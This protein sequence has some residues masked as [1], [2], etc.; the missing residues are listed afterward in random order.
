MF[1][2]P[3]RHPYYDKGGFFNE[4]SQKATCVYHPHNEGVT[5]ANC[6]R[7]HSFKSLTLKIYI[8]NHFIFLLITGEQPTP[9]LCFHSL[10]TLK[11]CSSMSTKALPFDSS[12]IFCEK[13]H[14][15]K[16]SWWKMLGGAYYLSFLFRVSPTLKSWAL[17]QKITFCKAFASIFNN[18]TSMLRQLFISIRINAA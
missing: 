13:L 2:S 16:Y 3:Y 12:S 14:E 6:W 1:H 10:M 5:L 18:L 7:Y 11:Y 9:V 15:K 8:M 17:L 4:Y